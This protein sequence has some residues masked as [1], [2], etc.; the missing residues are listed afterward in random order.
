MPT[1]D[2]EWGRARMGNASG[3]AFSFAVACTVA[4]AAAV[5]AQPSQQSDDAPTRRQAP[6][7]EVLSV[8]VQARLRKLAE[9]TSDSTG[10]FEYQIPDLLYRYH[11]NSH[12]TSS[13]FEFEH[14]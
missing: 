13:F 6:A 5:L 11:Q 2:G 3:V 4:A 7:R 8:T 12:A 1:L 14:V 9:A 10:K